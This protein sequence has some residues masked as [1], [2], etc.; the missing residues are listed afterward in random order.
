M[1]TNNTLR[2]VLKRYSDRIPKDEHVTIESENDPFLLTSDHLRVRLS[3]VKGYGINALYRTWSI[4]IPQ[5]I[6]AERNCEAIARVVDDAVAYLVSIVFPRPL[7]R[8]R[9]RRDARWG[10]S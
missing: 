8:F 7:P 9:I 6:F 3:R 4:D 1:S 10:R 2:V 5:R